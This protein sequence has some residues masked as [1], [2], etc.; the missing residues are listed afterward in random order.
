M[1]NLRF[2]SMEII[3]NK[4]PSQL[5]FDLNKYL[6]RNCLIY[7]KKKNSIESRDTT[8]MHMQLIN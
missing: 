6:S 7:K 2:F 1:K 3:T 8:N 4:L 5:S